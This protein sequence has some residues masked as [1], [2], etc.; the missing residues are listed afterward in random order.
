MTDFPE[1]CNP[2]SSPTPPLH[3]WLSGSGRGSIERKADAADEGKLDGWTQGSIPK[4]N[5]SRLTS[6]PGHEQ[7][8]KT[9]ERYLIAG[10]AGSALYHGF[11]GEIVLTDGVYGNFHRQLG[12]LPCHGCGKV[13]LLGPGHRVY[14]SA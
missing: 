9:I 7:P 1:I 6:I 13:L 5:P 2:Y 8:E 14:L 12:D 10:I 11:L 4:E 3:V